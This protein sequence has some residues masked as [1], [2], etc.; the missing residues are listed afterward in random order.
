MVTL[1]S[2]VEIKYASLHQLGSILVLSSYLL[3][4]YKNSN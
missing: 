2:G 4:F 3:I 1:I